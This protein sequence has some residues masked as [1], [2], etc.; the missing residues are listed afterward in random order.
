MNPRAGGRSGQRRGHEQPMHGPPCP[1]P[2]RFC[3]RTPALTRSSASLSPTIGN[4]GSTH[5]PV[6]KNLAAGGG[7]SESRLRARLALAGNRSARYA[8]VGSSNVTGWC[9]EGAGLA[10]SEPIPP[11]SSIRRRSAAS[12]VTVRLSVAWSSG[13][14]CPC[15]KMATGWRS[16][17]PGVR[18]DAHRATARS[19]T[20]GLRREQPGHAQC[21]E[22]HCPRQSAKTPMMNHISLLA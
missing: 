15:Q 2:A 10:V 7:P 13:I 3:T 17:M 18:L 16:P 8:P 12:A 14:S 4:R 9:S 20:R 6:R 21:G 1:P 11:S 19:S 5:R 22:Y